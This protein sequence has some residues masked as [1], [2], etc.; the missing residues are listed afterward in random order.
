MN[1]IKDCFR[2]WFNL[3]G[4]DIVKTRRKRLFSQSDSVRIGDFDL[5]L[6]KGHALPSYLLQ[7]PF[8][9][10]NLQRIV[11]YISERTSSTLYIID[12]GAN[13]GD[14]AALIMENSKDV[15]IT[16]IE[17]DKQY[18]P[19]LKANLS[20][21][22]NIKI[23]DQFL[24]DTNK[25]KN[26]QLINSEGTA[27]IIKGDSNA[28][29][30]TT[31]DQLYEEEP[32]IASSKLLKID[33][34]GFDLKIIRG[35]LKYIADKMP[36]LFFEYDREFLDA[37]ADDGISTLKTLQNIGYT[38]ML[39]YDNYGKLLLS[40]TEKDFHLFSQLDEYIKGKKAAFQY[41]DICFIHQ[42]DE[43][44]FRTIDE[45]ERL[46]FNQQVNALPH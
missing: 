41:Y 26:H 1:F 11:S 6:P 18:L 2:F 32:C 14:S 21:S 10:R 40:L 3:F 24:S 16:C 35:G 20:S 25:E 44:L 42:K 36:V 9:S 43:E 8:Y 38:F 31:I 12:V 39:I 7:F 33:T 30:F 13:V 22:Q 5:K 37:N 15:F 29:K 34:D 28:F 4:F 45:K 27:R 19:F 17:G 46:F 23:I